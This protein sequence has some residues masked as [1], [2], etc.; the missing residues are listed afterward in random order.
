RVME[1][2]LAL[3]LKWPLVI[4]NSALAV[5]SMIGTIRMGEEIIHVVSTYPIIDSISYGLDPYQPAAFWGLCFAFS[6]FF[7]LVDTIFVVL[8]KKKL[9]FLHW[10]HHAI[11][12]VYVWH[13]VKDSTAAGRWFVFMNYFVHSLMYAYYA[14]SAVGIRLPRS[15]CMTI[16]FLQ[17]AQM[18]IGVAISFI[19][20]YCK[21]EGMTVQHTYENLYFCFAIY[22]SFAVLFSN[23]FNKS[24]LKEEKKVYTVNNSTYPC[25]IAG[26]GNQ[27]YY[28]PYEYSA[29]I[30]PESWWHDNDQARL[31]KKINKSQI[32][33]ILKE[34]TYLVIQAYWRYTVHI[35]IAYNLRWPL[36][37]WNVALAVFSLI[38]TVRMGEELVHVVRTHPLID[39]ISYSPDPDQPAALWAFGFALSKFFEL[40]DTIFVVLRKKKLIFLHWYHHAIV[41]VY[42]W[43]A[44]KDG[45]AAGRWFIFMNYVVH[46]LMYTYYAI[47]AA[48]FRL[49]RRLSMTITTLQTT[50]MFI[51][52]TIS[53]IVFYCK[54]QGMTVQHTYENLYF[55]FAIYVSFAVLFSDFFSNSYL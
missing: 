40:M 54:L 14:V 38:G 30:G 24:Y 42:V 19:V 52:V 44:I 33:P 45:T 50:Q 41:L 2:R 11:V 36:I 48:G 12:L 35:A 8:R 15:L 21:M 28:I 26:H 5:F 32:I 55:C 3:N 47:T 49:P 4:W 31:N 17:T 1:G 27:M 37:G 13:A 51:G 6:K 39:S 23:F 46:S 18:F 29:L 9:I 7:E 43:H 16:T 22:V 10:Y 34:E 20:F 25:V 53:F